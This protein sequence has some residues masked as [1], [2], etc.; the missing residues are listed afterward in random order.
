MNIQERTWKNITLE[1]L[2]DYIKN[3]CKGDFECYQID[4]VPD[5]LKHVGGDFIL[6]DTYVEK[7]PDNLTV[8]G[9]LNLW[10]CE[11]LKGLPKGLKVGRDLMIE[12]SGITT[13]QQLPID[14]KVEGTI[15]SEMFTNQQAKAYLGTVSRLPELE[16]IL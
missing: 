9:D 3:G 15:R 2:G 4:V 8:E 14:L 7:L 5:T 10:G 1:K 11:K 6:Q 12:E 13:I 16:G